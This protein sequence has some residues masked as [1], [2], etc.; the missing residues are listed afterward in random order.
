MQFFAVATILSFAGAALASPV[1][2]RRQDICWLACFPTE[3]T[4]PEG[5]VRRLQITLI[6]NQFT[7]SIFS[8]PPVRPRVALSSA[9]TMLHLLPGSTG[10]GA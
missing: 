7:D 4:C 1:L 5:W 3:P 8:F 6:A 2:E 10:V 9:G